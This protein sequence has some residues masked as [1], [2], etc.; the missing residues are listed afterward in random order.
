MDRTSHNLRI[1]FGP[2][3]VQVWSL[4]RDRHRALNSIE[5]YQQVLV[6]LQE[7][8]RVED[9]RRGSLVNKRSLQ[10]TE[11]RDQLKYKE[12]ERLDVKKEIN[13]QDL[14]LQSFTSRAQVHFKALFLQQPSVG[15]YRGQ[16]ADN[17]QK[18]NSL[19]QE[20][21]KLKDELGSVIYRQKAAIDP[22]EDLHFAIDYLHQEVEKCRQRADEI[23]DSIEQRIIKRCLYGSAMQLELM[24]QNGLELTN[25]E[26]FCE[27]Y[28]EISNLVHNKSG[29]FRKNAK[30]QRPSFINDLKKSLYKERCE[31]SARL[32]MTG[33][34]LHHRK[35]KSGD[36]SRWR[37]FDGTIQGSIAKAFSYERQR[38]KSDT[39]AY[40]LCDQVVSSFLEARD[41]HLRNQENTSE[42]Q[43]GKLHE[44][45][46]CLWI[47]LISGCD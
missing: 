3:A 30:Y 2:A 15:H 1:F 26:T 20:K 40:V 7:D 29:R 8:L 27:L 17:I 37:T 19:Q 34:G 9:K 38:I 25:I 23:S 13:V 16:R 45:A 28:F 21:E 18:L 4:W 43:F 10:V 36:N 12:C 33:R 39:L 46:G 31:Y 41:S 5:V 44:L 24:L 22:I 11:V 32:D 6:G 35:V 42:K 47:E 14:K